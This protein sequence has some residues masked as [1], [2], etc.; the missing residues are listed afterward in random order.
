[1]SAFVHHAS[2]VSSPTHAA[3]KLEAIRGWLTHQTNSLGGGVRP[4]RCLVLTGPAGSGKSTAARLVAQA[5]GYE[6]MEWTPPMPTLWDEHAS[7]S[8]GG[9]NGAGYTSKVRCTCAWPRL[10]VL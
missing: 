8:V 3:Q 5:A 6:V 4:G 2:P 7:T 1:M 9:H 10:C